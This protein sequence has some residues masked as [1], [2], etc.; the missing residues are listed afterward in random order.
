MKKKK[1]VGNILRTRTSR[2]FYVPFYVMI[3]ILVFILIYIQVTGRPIN[4]LA[5]KIALVFSIIILIVTEVHRFGNSYEI[6]D[7][8]VIHKNGY[9]TIL[10]KRLEFGAISD[11]D[12]TQNPWQ[13]ILSYGNVEIHL[14]SKENKT[15]IRNINNPNGFVDF[16]QKKMIASGGR[17]R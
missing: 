4:S 9:L 5:L 7:N 6:N 1:G 13:R 11:S 8:S 15:M 3:V 16:L 12:V 2:K 14:Y 17:R 10:S